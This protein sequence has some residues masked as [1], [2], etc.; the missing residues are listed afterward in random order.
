[1]GIKATGIVLVTLSIYNQDL[2]I[3]ANEALRSELMSYILATSFLF[4]YLIYR[5]RKMLSATI[6]FESQRTKKKAI[7]AHEMMG[8]LLCLLAFL[9]YWH[10]S[11]TFNP[12]EYHIVSLP[13]F[14]A[15]LILVTISEKAFKI[16][17]FTAKPRLT[18]CKYHNQNPKSE[19]HFCGACGRILNPMKINL[20]G[21]ET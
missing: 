18:P 3:V 13:I 19:Q 5:K 15:G 6:P 14:T 2:A 12:L 9:L 10:G 20:S 17:L 8:A 16:R 4:T 7:Q 11:Y 21:R 1:L